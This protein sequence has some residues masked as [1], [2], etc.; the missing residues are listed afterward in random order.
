MESTGSIRAPIGAKLILNSNYGYLGLS[1]DTS[2]SE[3]IKKSETVKDNSEQNIE[4]LNDELC[5]QT[6][7][8]QEDEE[9]KV[10]KDYLDTINISVAAIIAAE[11]RMFMLPYR[12]DGST[13]LRV[14]IQILLFLQV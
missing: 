2:K 9:N 4:T 10:D 6:R 12:L 3:I 13:A 5:I 14:L 1:E 11:A 7:E 8:L